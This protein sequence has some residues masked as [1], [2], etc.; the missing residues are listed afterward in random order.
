LT[1]ATFHFLAIPLQTSW[2]SLSN[3]SGNV[4]H[5]VCRCFVF[6]GGILYTHVHPLLGAD[7]VSSK[8]R[9]LITAIEDEC[10]GLTLCE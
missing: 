9:Q 6:F 8:S 3:A 7:E 4:I 2:L 10:D 1:E 5:S